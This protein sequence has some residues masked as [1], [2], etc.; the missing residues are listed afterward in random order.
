MKRKELHKQKI[1]ASALGYA[2][3]FLLLTALI[4]CGVLFIASVNKRLEMNYTVKEH[5]LFDNYVSLIYGAKT[6]G[7]TKATIFHP[8][9]DTSEIHVK[10]WGA[11]RVVT[12]NT[13]HGNRVV[14]RSA[15]IGYEM[16]TA[17][18]ALYLPDNNQSLKLCGDT[19]IEGDAFLPERGLERSYI[20]GKNYENDKLLYG[21][22][23]KSEL[24]LPAL[25]KMYADLSL[26]SFLGNAKKTAFFSKDST[27]AFDQETAIV[28]QIEPLY[29]ANKIQGNIILHSFDSI[30]VAAT[31]RL[32]NVILVSPYVRFEKGFTGTVQV[33][34]HEKIVC[35]QN[36]KL[37]YPSVLVM[38]EIS[39]HQNAGNASVEIQEGA[40][41]TGGILLTS[42]NFNFRNPVHLNIAPKAIVGG[43]VYNQGETSLY[44]KIIGNIYTNGFRINAGGGVYTNQLLDAKI[45]G[46]SL[47]AEFLYPDWLEKMEFKDAKIITCF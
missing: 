37:L 19:K 45:L 6:K 17:L 24:A 9:G 21:T 26:E 46:T 4:C 18:P 39:F 13:K 38:N 40:R 44:G 15:L 10:S 42:R 22:Q 36:V 25:N 14:S 35:E 3:A 5:M 16:E 12:V 30:Y 8:A 47:P 1:P 34:A 33:I 28:S 11:F 2:I 31:A 29:I 32:E 7:Q 27:F 20:A 41:I 23:H 43:L